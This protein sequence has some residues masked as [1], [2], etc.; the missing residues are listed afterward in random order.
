[1]S[2]IK[3]KCQ[4]AFSA[5]FEAEKAS[6]PEIRDCYIAPALTEQEYNLPAIICR[7]A[8]ASEIAP[9]ANIWEVELLIAVASHPDDDTAQALGLDR[10]SNHA[11]RT[12]AVYELLFDVTQSD[13]ALRALAVPVLNVPLSGPDTRA[14]KQF[15]CSGY[16]QTDEADGRTSR[17]VED[18]FTLLV[19]CSCGDP[20]V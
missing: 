5:Y 11:S 17:H 6:T 16:I 12:R 8:K 20:D 13:P 7:A 9:G 10:T 3:Q 1:M 14:V 15:T 18:S 19:T 2:A 4:A